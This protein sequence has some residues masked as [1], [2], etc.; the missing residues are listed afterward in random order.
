MRI[1]GTTDAD[2]MIIHGN[3]H[4]AWVNGAGDPISGAVAL[5]ETVRAFSRL[6]E[7]GWRPR[8]TIVFALWDGEEWGLLGSTEWAEHHREVL[9]EQ[10]V[11][12]FN[13]DSNSRGWFGG[14][15]SHTLET[16]VRQV[17]RDIQDP[18][19]G[20]SALGAL[21]ERALDNA[22]TAEDSTRAAITRTPRLTR[23]CVSSLWVPVA[24]GT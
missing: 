21:K 8:R 1:P 17:A 14:S 18:R 15:G 12:Y 7:T 5:M 22:A 23:Y 16:F 20:K 10:A 4:D 2:Q 19:T 13:S 3:H 11:I 24:D 6:L 9:N